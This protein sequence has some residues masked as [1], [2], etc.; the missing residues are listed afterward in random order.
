M[1]PG[2]PNFFLQAMQAWMQGQED[3]R[4][5]R[6]Q[7]MREQQAQ[8]ERKLRLETLKFEQNRIKLED[9]IRAAT[10]N[11]QGSMDA[12]KFMEGTSTPRME[13]PEGI[14]GPPQPTGPTA[15]QIPGISV[16]EAGID[17]PG[18]Q[19]PVRYAEDLEA[20][21]ARQ[22]E[23]KMRQAIEQAG[24]IAEAQASG[25]ARVAQAPRDVPGVGTVPG[26]LADNFLSMF[27]AAAQ[28]RGQQEFSRTQAQEGRQHDVRMEGIRSGNA[29]TLEQ[30]R[31]AAA[32]AEEGNK[33]LSGEA[34]KVLAVATTL[35]P[36]V[37]QLKAA[38]AKDYQRSVRGI[39]TGTDRRLTRLV[40]QV[41]D[42]V[43][44]LRS[45]GAINKDEENRFK[46]QIASLPDLAFGDSQIAIDALDGIL[47]EAN[48][49]AASV[50]P[51][52]G[53]RTANVQAGQPAPRMG[54]GPTVGETRTINGQPA[55]WD[56]RGWLPA[57]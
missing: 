11:R 6:E 56:G 26:D 1:A 12:L 7:Q 19:A 32:R 14:P 53:G 15:M 33:P 10:M 16:P 46:R 57:R 48:Q 29:R 22:Q 30:E 24:G 51:G 5:E 35:G 9:K 27:Q 50:R 21:L 17:V 55:R 45:G 4:R 44:R 34:A 28:Q 52:V 38:F 37:E 42:K 3:G 25:T 18:F 8:E 40:D 31:R 2:R 47:A 54:S 39:V 13:L 20:Q 36:E 49:V 41:A 43:G 23:M